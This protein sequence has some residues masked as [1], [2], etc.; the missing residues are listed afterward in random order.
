MA[1]SLYDRPGL[2]HSTVLHW[3]SSIVAAFA[4]WSAALNNAEVSR[5]LTGVA[6]RASSAIFSGGVF[7]PS[8]PARSVPCWFCPD[9][10]VRLTWSPALP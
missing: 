6:L 7:V 1:K 5:L 10:N 8:L 3:A 9:K 4:G 2:A